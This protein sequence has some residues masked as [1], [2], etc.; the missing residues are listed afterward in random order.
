MQRVT[1]R[2]VKGK[3]GNYCIAIF[4]SNDCRKDASCADKTVGGR[5]CLGKT[6]SLNA[7]ELR[8]HRRLLRAL[9]L[10]YRLHNQQLAQVLQASDWP[11]PD[12]LYYQ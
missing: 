6:R 7:T 4:L 3:K 10:Y 8:A 12:W 11:R 2:K 5:S 9:Q 1:D